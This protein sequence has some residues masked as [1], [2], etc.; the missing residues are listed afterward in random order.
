MQTTTRERTR[1][2]EALRSMTPCMARISMV[3]VLIGGLKLD[4]SDNGLFG[5]HPAS[6]CH[7]DIVGHD[8]CAREVQKPA[9]SASHIVGMHGSNH[10]GERID[11]E[12]LLVVLTPHQA[13]R[14]AGHP[15]D[16]RVDHD[17]NCCQPGVPV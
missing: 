1:S 10:F 5:S 17:S 3:Q 2:S 14:D 15:H 7:P 16:G 13:L 9:E 4:G 11:Q 6:N 12:T 8:E